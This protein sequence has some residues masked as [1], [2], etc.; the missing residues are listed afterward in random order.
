MHFVI[1]GIFVDM[2][3]NDEINPIG[4]EMYFFL[5]RFSGF[6]LSDA[7]YYFCNEIDHEDHED[8]YVDE[9]PRMKDF[10]HPEECYQ[11]SVLAGLTILLLLDAVLV[12]CLLI[13]GIVTNSLALEKA[14]VCCC[15]CCEDS[16][17]QMQTQMPIAF[18]LSADQ[19][20][21]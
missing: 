20:Y 16:T 9:D 8:H 11:Y 19:V 17:S 7:E 3:R 21:K 18:Y 14:K 4:I 2:I 5:H 13:W 15:Q 6:D 12:F 10:S 1:G